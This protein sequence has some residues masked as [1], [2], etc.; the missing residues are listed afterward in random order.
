M[1]SL[2]HR[3]V[4]RRV[5][6]RPAAYG[7]IAVGV[8][9]RAITTAGGHPITATYS[10]DPTHHVSAGT[11]PLT[12]TATPTLFQLAL[13]YLIAFAHNLHLFGL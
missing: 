9:T 10:G 13:G 2:N 3:Q 7:R 1:V 12:V 4:T 5:G 11:T 8:V 6:R